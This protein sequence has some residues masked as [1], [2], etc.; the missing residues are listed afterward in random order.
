MTEKVFDIDHEVCKSLA[1][2]VGVK[3]VKSRI[4]LFKTQPRGRRAE[5][6][7]GS[8]RLYEAFSLTQ[9]YFGQVLTWFNQV[10]DTES[11]F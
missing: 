8:S 10:G 4:C 5:Q 6:T 9:S 2:W 1:S 7:T 3:E 11:S